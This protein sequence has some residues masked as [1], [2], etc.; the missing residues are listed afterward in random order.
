MAAEA[1]AG[2]GTVPEDRGRDSDWAAEEWAEV[3]A[4]RDPARVAEAQELVA[5]AEAA[6]RVRAEV[7]GRAE[8]AEDRVAAPVAA[9]VL[10]VDREAR[11][12]EALAPAEVGEQEPDLVVA[13]ERALAER[14]RVEAASAE[15]E[16]V[17]VR[18]EAE[19]SAAGVVRAEELVLAQAADTEHPENG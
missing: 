14:V 11:E 16:L 13:E 15:A 4:A 19:D 5:R 17:R 2:R 7:C 12:A 6:G 8:R 1:R 10:V 18:V 3:E 9:Q